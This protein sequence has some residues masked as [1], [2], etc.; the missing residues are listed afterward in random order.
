MQM[1]FFW[2]L[3]NILRSEPETTLKNLIS[4]D[5]H[6]NLGG[7]FPRMRS[8]V[9]KKDCQ[10]VASVLKSRIS[11]SRNRVP[12]LRQPFTH[13]FLCH[14]IRARLWSTRIVTSKYHLWSLVMGRSIVYCSICGCPFEDVREGYSSEEGSEEGSIWS[15]SHTKVRQTG[16]VRFF[17]TISFCLLPQVFSR[18]SRNR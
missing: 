5:A 1:R 9:V 16:N 2:Y 3:I 13:A 18:F 6:T 7:K 17:S 14:S 15:A 4:G 10:G 11:K 12:K 8:N